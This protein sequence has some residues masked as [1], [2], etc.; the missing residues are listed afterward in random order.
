MRLGTLLLLSTA[1]AFAQT[2]DGGVA[3]SVSRTITVTADEADFSIA[4]GAA[5]DTTQQ[6]IAQIFLDAGVSG[7][8]HAGTSLGQSY[9][10]STSPATVQTQVQYLF[11]FSTPAAGFKDVAKIMETVR[12]KPPALLKSFQ[13]S[14]ALNAS[15]ATID[16]MRQT[17][18]PL[19]IADAQ[20]K[21]QGLATAA[22][23]KLGGIRSVS[24][25]YY[26]IN[27]SVNWIGTS[28]FGSTFSST[29]TSSGTQFTFSAGVTF[30][31]AQ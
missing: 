30:S 26:A 14:A 27:S 12:T 13:Y 6:Q 16:A 29:N 24:D 9:D 23:L 10:Y 17:T 5:L 7:L 8:T 1:A 2:T 22:G 11:T 19:L 15:Q 25:S 21:A 4:A 20:K 18:L 3:T 31:A 28:S